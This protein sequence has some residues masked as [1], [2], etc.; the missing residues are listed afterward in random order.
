L[1][2]MIFFYLHAV[3]SAAWISFHR[4]AMNRCEN[5]SL[6]FRFP[7]FRQQG[8]RR[9]LRAAAALPLHALPGPIYIPIGP[10][11][12]GKTTLLRKIGAVDVSLDDQD[13]VYRAV[14]TDLFLGDRPPPPGPL[15]DRLDSSKRMSGKYP[16]DEEIRL[17]LMKLRGEIGAGDM[18][19]ALRRIERGPG[20]GAATLLR[21][22]EDLPAPIALPE[23]VDLFVPGAIFPRG[24]R[25]A[26]RSLSSAAADA[27]LGP[28][29]WGNTNT[30]PGDYATALGTAA[31]Y[32][33]PV[34]FLVYGGGDDAGDDGYGSDDT[35]R[36]PAVGL[37]ELMRRSVRRLCETGRYVPMSA[38]EVSLG[39]VER[40]VSKS[41]REG[42]NGIGMEVA[43]SRMAGY[44]MLADRTVRKTPE[45]GY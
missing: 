44:E 39:R 20:S 43:L 29:A 2:N 4:R 33:R 6:L 9:N 11:C 19:E 38:V 18:R 21:A 16:A 45:T 10:P 3:P 36:L 13:G 42:G 17:I 40:L 7:T 26:E 24:L 23:T 14:P 34:I 1:S 32:G 25:A 12:C 15:G 8:P 5:A 31:A 22:T 30:R 27:A 28:L 37:G 41:R 35:F